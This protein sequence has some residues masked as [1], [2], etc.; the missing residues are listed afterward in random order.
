M[1]VWTV[2]RWN[3][4]MSYLL[5]VCDSE[6]TAKKA[7]ELD[8]KFRKHNGADTKFSYTI[9]ARN[10]YTEKDAAE[11]EDYYYRRTAEGATYI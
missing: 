11:M 2:T 7:V 10:I 5:S 3:T 4:D 1:T 8:R 6:E 9:E